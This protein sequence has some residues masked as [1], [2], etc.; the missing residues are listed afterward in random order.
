MGVQKVFVGHDKLGEHPS[1]WLTQSLVV[2][3]CSLKLDVSER[4]GNHWEFQFTSYHYV[5]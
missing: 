5:K 2:K 3:F 1:R 4:S